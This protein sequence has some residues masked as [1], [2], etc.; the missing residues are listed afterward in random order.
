MKLLLSG[1]DGRQ[2][3]QTN[4]L[5]GSSYFY[6]VCIVRHAIENKLHKQQYKVS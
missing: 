2:V 3:M 6:K 4:R 1:N 5:D